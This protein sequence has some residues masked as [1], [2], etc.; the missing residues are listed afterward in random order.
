MKFTAT[1]GCFYPGKS[2]SRHQTLRNSPNF[3]Q[4]STTQMYQPGGNYSAFLRIIASRPMQTHETKPDTG[5]DCPVPDRLPEN[6]LNLIRAR[7]FASIVCLVSFLFDRRSLCQPGSN[8]SLIFA[9]YYL[10]SLKM[11][12]SEPYAGPDWQ[13]SKTGL[14]TRQLR[15]NHAQNVPL[16]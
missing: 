7:L 14:P 11:N 3:L 1:I 13:Y 16:R 12:Q 9:I 8:Y 4:F 5:S 2:V 15:R 6:V 10:T